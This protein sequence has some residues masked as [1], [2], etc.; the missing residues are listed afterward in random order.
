[1]EMGRIECDASA[2]RLTQAI[3]LRLTCSAA[4]E[5]RLSMATTAKGSLQQK[6]RVIS[7][8]TLVDGPY[9]TPWPLLQAACQKTAPVAPELG[10][11]PPG[12]HHAAFSC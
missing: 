10:S 1:M 6:L 8:A 5:Y 4:A 12:Q 3:I 11:S 7:T 2:K 9:R